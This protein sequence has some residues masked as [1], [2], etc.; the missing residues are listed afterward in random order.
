M[1]KILLAITTYLLS[2][3]IF[4]QTVQ[5]SSPDG[6]IIVSVNDDKTPS[7]SIM[8]NN[9]TVIADSRLGL[10][11][12]KSAELGEGFTIKETEKASNDSIWQQP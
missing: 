12:K 1:N 8:L 3:L 11:F 6:K 7:Y 5:I 2:P 10:R 4:A 9:K